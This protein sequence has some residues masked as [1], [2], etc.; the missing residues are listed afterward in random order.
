MQTILYIHHG[1]G[2]GGAGLSLLYLIKALDRKKFHPVVLF[3]YQSSII[4]LFKDAGIDVVGPIGVGDF[5]HTRIW[6]FSWYH[7]PY[8]LKALK[9][10]LLTRYSLADKWLDLVK[11]DLVH[12]NTSSLIAWAVVA[13]QKKIPVVWH[14]RE[15]LAHGY[16]GIRKRFIEKVIARYADY[17]IP[18]SH[19]DGKPWLGLQKTFVTHNAV[20]GRTFDYT[21]FTASKMLKRYGIKQGDPVILFLGGL[22]EQKGTLE[23]LLIFQQLLKIMPQAKL[24]VAGYFSMQNDGGHLRI[25]LSPFAWYKRRVQRVVEQLAESVVF[26]GAIENVP[27]VMAAS[28]VVV[29]PASVG[30]FARPIIEAGFMKKP[31]IAS[32]L[33]PLDELVRDGYT[34]FLIPPYKQN[35]WVEKLAMLLTNTAVS[36]HMGQCAYE[37]CVQRF[38]MNHYV[39]KIERLYHAALK[40]EETHSQGSEKYET[41]TI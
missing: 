34:G 29:F 20:D 38:H 6:S 4:K 2:I 39:R 33:A 31:V 36:D 13:S 26:L 15:P 41:P 9:D 25:M 11:P 10:T 8:F 32:A 23:I 3:L 40:K 22:S 24:L 35:L 27:E 21:R 19:T 30:H 12:L 18:I 1:K 14:I 7:A 16:L 37:F 5:P 28:R 17:I